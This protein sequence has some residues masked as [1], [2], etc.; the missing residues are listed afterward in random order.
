MAF[1]YLQLLFPHIIKFLQFTWQKLR[2]WWDRG[3]HFFDH[4]RTKQLIQ[5]EYEALYI[6]PEFLI[7]HRLGQLVAATWTAFFFMPAFPTMFAYL[8][9]I[10]FVFY[11]FDKI[12]FLRY[13]R[14][15]R[16][17]DEKII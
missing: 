10:V 6:G 15:P 17:S 12:L 2:A 9:V 11:W 4:N 7:E 13:Y 16:N 1:I 3:L 14:V 8:I 5:S